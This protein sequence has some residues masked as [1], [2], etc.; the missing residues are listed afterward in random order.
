MG[1]LITSANLIG[2]YAIPKSS[3]SNLDAFINDVEETY[4][5]D[6][7]GA[8]LWATIKATVTGTPPKPVGTGYLNV[9]NAFSLDYGSKIY[10]SKGLVNMLCGF[11]FFDY[12]IQAK[13]KATEMGM[14]EVNPD[15]QKVS[16]AANLY[17]YLNEATES[18]LSIQ[19]Y[20]QNIHPELFPP[21]IAPASVVFNGQDK[22]YGIS[23]LG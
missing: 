21:I 16:T 15:T 2:K 1:V 7:F 6:L 17:T 12:M 19:E 3:Y 22:S 5:N 20:I 4:L 13:Y 18:F 10:K 23:L 11:I 9:Y 14:T 8:D